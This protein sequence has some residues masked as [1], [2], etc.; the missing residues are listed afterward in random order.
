MAAEGR[1]TTTDLK[2][3]RTAPGKGDGAAASSRGEEATGAWVGVEHSSVERRLY[4]ECFTFDFFQAVR[5]LQKLDPARVPVGF[6]GPP[7]REAVRFRAHNSLSFPPSSIYDLQLPSS[8]VPVP[9]LVQAFLG[10]TGPSGVLPRHYTELL[11]RLD[12]T[13]KGPEKHALRDWFDLFNHRVVSLFYRAWEKYRFFILYERRD[14]P[15]AE[16]DPFTSCLF[17]LVGLGSAPLRGRLRITT[18]EVGEHEPQEKILAQVRDLGLLRYAGLLGHRPRCAIALEAMLEDYLQVRASVKQFQ[19][20]WL[21]IEPS[22]RSFLQTEPG[23]NEL[24][25]ST[26]VG[27]RIWDVQSKFRVRLGP[28]DYRQFLGLLPDRAPV[29]ERKAFFL[30]VH[31]TRLYV[32]PSIDFDVQLVLKAAEVPECVLA[33]QPAFGARLG[34]NTWLISGSLPHD[35]DDAVFEGEEVTRLAAS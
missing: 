4:E 14:S 10:L 3:T 30:L 26:V 28:L 35:A 34:W 24:G 13:G 20:Q 22:S 29:P 15:G 25:V 8:H 7:R 32:D 1:R 33:D 31:L 23:N 27:E 21:P 18:T 12:R 16:P 19:G 17:S 9:V 11:I 2:A 5:L 6:S